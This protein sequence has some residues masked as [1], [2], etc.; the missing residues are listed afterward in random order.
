MSVLK[1]TNDEWRVLLA[2]QKASGQTQEEW[3]KANGVNLYTLRDR[4]SRLKKQD[5][6]AAGHAS[7]H[8]SKISAG[9]VEIKP[10][11]IIEENG[12]PAPAVK[13]DKHRPAPA[14]GKLL[15]HSPKAAPKKKAT[16]IYVTCG[17]WT[18]IV[19]AGCQA[20]L[21]AD[22]LKAVSQACC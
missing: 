11:N 14:K 15:A 9:W 18:V 2:E 12:L 20:G 10:E 6:E 21:L 22:V 1:R 4:A 16:D 5:R 17:D 7:Q 8:D 3:C 13:T 19:S